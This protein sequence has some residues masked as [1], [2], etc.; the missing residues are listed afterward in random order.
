M[1]DIQ[2]NPIRLNEHVLNSIMSSTNQCIIY[3]QFH[4]RHPSMLV[5]VL[6]CHNGFCNSYKVGNPLIQLM[7]KVKL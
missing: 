1:A 6:E 3:S 7:L 2:Y 5:H 4:I